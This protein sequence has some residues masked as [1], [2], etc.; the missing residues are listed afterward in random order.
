MTT[1]T[2]RIV[3]VLAATLVLGACQ[4]TTAPETTT[5]PRG[6]PAASVAATAST[7]SATAMA[8]I[9]ADLVDAT[10][11]F[12]V[13]IEDAP[14]RTDL[15]AALV[16]LTA[17]LSAGDTATAASALATARER[18]AAVPGD[19]TATEL[20]PVGLALDAVEQVLQGTL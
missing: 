11:S 17:A 6:A 4:D 7:A 5:G 12:L 10:E 19:A 1:P 18:L 2:V 8:A 16:A 13:G 14:A 20:A 3:A 9:G 15:R